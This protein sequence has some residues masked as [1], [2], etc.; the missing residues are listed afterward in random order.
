MKLQDE[1][2]RDDVDGMKSGIGR[3]LCA[4]FTRHTPLALGIWIYDMMG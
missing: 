3:A 2:M 1:V 4:L